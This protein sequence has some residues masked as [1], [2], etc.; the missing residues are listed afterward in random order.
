MHANEG[1]EKPSSEPC[2]R[3]VIFAGIVC[4]GT[5]SF[6]IRFTVMIH[7]PSKRFMHCCEAH[8]DGLHVMIPSVSEPH[9]HDA[10]AFQCCSPSNTAST[11]PSTLVFPRSVNQFSCLLPRR[12]PNTGSTVAKR[13][14]IICWPPPESILA[15]IY[16]MGVKSTCI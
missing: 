3:E 9:T 11:A 1:G 10:P 7:A 14:V 8:F 12:L 16:S 5:V 6:L 2:I 15:F 4:H 13:P